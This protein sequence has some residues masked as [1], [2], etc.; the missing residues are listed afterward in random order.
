MGHSPFDGSFQG[1]GLV[2]PVYQD[3]HLLAVGYG[4]DPNSQCC[5]RDLIDVVI[6]KPAVHDFGIIG[7]ALDAG[8]AAETGKRFVESDVAV[9]TDSTQKELNATIGGDCIFKGFTLGYQVSG[10]AIEDMYVLLLD[11]DVAEEIVPHEG[12]VAL[13][14]L[15]LQTYILIHVEGHHMLKGDVSFFVELDKFSIRAQR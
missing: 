2:V 14:V 13:L 11:V 12:V 9:R 8:L 3:D 7:K 4:L 6:E 15:S 5:R 10:H 1:K